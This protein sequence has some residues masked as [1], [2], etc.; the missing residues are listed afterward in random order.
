MVYTACSR[1]R[2]G[3][4]KSSK[5]CSISKYFMKKIKQKSSKSLRNS[6]SQLEFQC[7]SIYISWI[8]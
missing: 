3:Y 4:Y 1:S 8:L 2:Y 7:S 5:D 6:R